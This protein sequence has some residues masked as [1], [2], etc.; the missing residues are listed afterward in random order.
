M[1]YFN[2]YIIYSLD[3]NK[4]FQIIESYIGDIVRSTSTI[5]YNFSKFFFIFCD[6]HPTLNQLFI[7]SK[8]E[9]ERHM[10]WRETH[11]NCHNK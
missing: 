10:K 9:S 6:F 3:S 5:Q 7:H 1:I 4:Q 8:T 2:S 11:V